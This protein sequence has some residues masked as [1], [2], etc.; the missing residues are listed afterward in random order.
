MGDWWQR[1]RRR[2]WWWRITLRNKFNQLQG[3]KITLSSSYVRPRAGRS[4]RNI[5]GQQVSQSGRHAPLSLTNVPWNI[6]SV[7]PVTQRRESGIID[8]WTGRSFSRR[9]SK[10]DHV[11]RGNSVHLVWLG[12]S[13]ASVRP[14]LA[15]PLCLVLIPG[16][17]PNRNPVQSSYE[18]QSLTHHH[19]HWHKSGRTGTSHSHGSSHSWD[20]IAI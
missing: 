6:R 3:D 5:V 2:W 10:S 11:Q 8:I 16:K 20:I 17:F 7:F 1:L 4:V 15:L 18:E 19:H 12:W 13:G 9:G 14:S